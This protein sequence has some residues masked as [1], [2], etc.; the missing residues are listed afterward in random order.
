MK[1]VWIMPTHGTTVGWLEAM[2]RSMDSCAYTEPDRAMV[3]VARIGRNA[4][5]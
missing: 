4:F 1:C 2:V 3:A 5:I